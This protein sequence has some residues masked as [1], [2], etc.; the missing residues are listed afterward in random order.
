MISL[1][2]F[3]KQIYDYCGNWF[4]H[5]FH[6][7]TF[8]THFNLFQSIVK[9]IDNAGK[10]RCT[11]D[12]HRFAFFKMGYILGFIALSFQLAEIKLSI[13]IDSLNRSSCSWA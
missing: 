12:F 5:S 7:L 1:K 2:T 9:N 13:V 8:L 4:P 11:N 10:T 6:K 3:R